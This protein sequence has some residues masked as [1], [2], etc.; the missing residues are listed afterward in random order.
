ML[1]INLTRSFIHTA[2]RSYLDTPFVM[3]LWIRNFNVRRYFPDIDEQRSS[4]LEPFQLFQQSFIITIIIITLVVRLLLLDRRYTQ[5]VHL[6]GRRGQVR[7]AVTYSRIA[8]VAPEN[9]ADLLRARTAPC[10]LVHLLFQFSLDLRDD[11]PFLLLPPLLLILVLVLVLH[12][13]RL[14]FARNP[15]PRE[16]DPLLG[17]GYGFR[18]DVIDQTSLDR[19][20][21]FSFLRHALLDDTNLCL[22]LLDPLHR[23]RRLFRGPRRAIGLLD[24]AVRLLRGISFPDCFSI[25]RYILRDWFFAF[26]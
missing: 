21:L 13:P 22:L 11:V 20:C 16:I 3:P 2:Q 6:L 10:L 14:P 23:T 12:A 9:A 15:R 24:Q 8:G 4:I 26:Q 7:C 19:R 18:A 25:R 17:R 5:L 1:P